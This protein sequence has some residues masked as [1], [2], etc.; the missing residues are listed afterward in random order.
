M[1]FAMKISSFRFKHVWVIVCNE[2]VV[3]ILVC[4][5]KENDR[6]FV[7]CFFFQTNFDFLI[8]SLK[9]AWPQLEIE[10]KIHIIF[11]FFF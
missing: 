7:C 2:I 4:G 10:K 11:C 5:L 6:M 3:S 8:S 9:I 1:L